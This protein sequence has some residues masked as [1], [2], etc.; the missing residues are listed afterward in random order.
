MPTLLKELYFSQEFVRQLADAM[1]QVY[2][3]FERQ[4][5]LE[6]ALD[7]TWPGR[8][9][10]DRMRHLS[11]CL[12]ATLPA[13]FPDTLALLRQAAPSFRGLQA[14]VFCDY[15][16]VYGLEHWELSLPALGELTVLGSSEFAPQYVG[17]DGRGLGLVRLAGAAPVDVLADASRGLQAPLGLLRPRGVA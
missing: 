7:E 16:E 13:D 15:I 11:H 17:L 1:C 9:L 5:F 10:K 12:H 2:A 14:M 6:L 8:E 4:R 3:P